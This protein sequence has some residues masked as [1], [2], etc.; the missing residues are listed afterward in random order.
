MRCKKLHHDPK[1]SAEEQDAIQQVVE[2][3]TGRLAL[4]KTD[5]LEEGDG[6]NMTLDRDYA[7]TGYASSASD[8]VRI[9]NQA[10]EDKAYRLLDEELT[11]D[12]YKRQGYHNRLISN[13]P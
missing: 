9:L 6:G 10:A 7:G 1:K 4:E 11:E 8:I 13:C 3:E 2:H 5:S 12:V